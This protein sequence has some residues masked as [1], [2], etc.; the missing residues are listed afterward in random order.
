MPRSKRENKE[1]IELRKESI[2]DSA[3]VLFALYG[4]NSV[5]LD[6]IAKVSK[7]SRPL[8]YH[9][10]KD[11]EG[12]FR[13]MMRKNV[14]RILE[15]TSSLDFEKP[16]YEVLKDLIEK[17]L[18]AIKN[19]NYKNPMSCVIYLL[20][21]LYLQK[22]FVP[23]PLDIEEERPLYKKRLFQITY[24]LIEKGQNEGSICKEDPKELTIAVLS[25]VKGLAYNKIYLR[26]KFICPSLNI[27]MGMFNTKEGNL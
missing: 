17:M 4:Y 5:G 6:D 24:Y 15:I 7:C 23:K 13:H 26:D 20:L 1:I 25:L 8:I 19:S 10:F 11:K 18:T 9:Y 14:R 27:L 12:V 16:A 22:D 21:N 3:L 2:L